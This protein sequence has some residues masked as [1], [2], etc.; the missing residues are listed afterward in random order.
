MRSDCIFEPGRIT[1]KTITKMIPFFDTVCVL[2][3]SGSTL[4][5]TLEAGVSQYPAY[6]GRFPSVSGM[7]F[8][9]DSKKP[10]FQ[11]VVKESVVLEKG[12]FREDGLYKVAV[13]GFI[14]DGN[15]YCFF[16]CFLFIYSSNIKNFQGKDGYDVLKNCKRIVDHENAMSIQYIVAEFFSN[17]NFLFL[18]L[19]EIGKKI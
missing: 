2:E 14:A 3:L 4:L 17:Y 6:D 18:K 11:R 7:K 13:K 15:Y 16:K 9:F 12:E 5:E 8:T 1:L 19:S 10:M